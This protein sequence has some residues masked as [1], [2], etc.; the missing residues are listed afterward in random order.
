MDFEATK[1]LIIKHEGIKQFPYICTA[2]KLTIGIGRNLEDKGLS[3]SEINFLFYNDIREV[4]ID[5]KKIFDNW[6]SID[7]IRQAV[8]TDMRFNL[9]YGGFRSFKRLISAIKRK[10]YILAEVEM[11]DSEWAQQLPERANELSNMMKG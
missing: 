6:D 1:K 9:G 8:L 5:L 10:D 3:D 11:L 4:V 7:D 2:D